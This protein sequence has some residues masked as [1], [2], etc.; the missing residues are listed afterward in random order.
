MAGVQSFYAAQTIFGHLLHHG[1]YVFDRFGKGGGV[2]EDCD[3]IGP[4]DRL[5][6]F[7]SGKFLG[8]NIGF[9]AFF[10]K[11]SKRMFNISGGFHP[12]QESGN[13]GTSYQAWS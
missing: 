11:L 3:T 6:R 2:G 9:A 10:Q 1:P 5:D 8:L 7:G 13:V 4:V 12:D